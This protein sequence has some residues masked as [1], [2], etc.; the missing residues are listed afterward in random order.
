MP[1]YCYLVK[2]KP[3]NAKKIED[4]DEK[5]ST[6]KMIAAKISIEAY[7]KNK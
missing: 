4:I 6:S 2:T 5:D 7:L 3:Q 1:I